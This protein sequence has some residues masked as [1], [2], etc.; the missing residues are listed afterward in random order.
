[1]NS[2]EVGSTRAL[3][4]DVPDDIERAVTI[5]RDGGLV[6]FPT[7]TVYGLGADASNDAAV[8][9]IFAAKGRPADHPL[10]VHLA[11][12]DALTDWASDIPDAAWRLAERF[13]P[14]PL[15]LILKRAPGVAEAASAGLPTL[16]LRVPGH[17]VARALLTR[18]GGGI[19]APSANRFGRISPTSADHVSAELD[20][21]ID[22]IVDGGRCEV[23]LESTILDLSGAHPQVL[24]PGH[25]GADALA[26]VIGPVRT[27]ARDAPVVPGSL[28]A[29]YAPATPMRLVPAETLEAEAARAAE[30][31]PVAVLARRAP[32]GPVA[33]RWIRLDADAEAYGRAL[34]ARLREADA[35]GVAH[36]LVEQVP[37]TPPWEAVRDRLRRA[38]AGSQP[39]PDTR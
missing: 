5:L 18:F 27:I 9:R 32:S 30:T 10:I 13:W 20:G 36:L 6:A 31:G 19:A 39:R 15:T 14:G 11:S 24:R 4:G 12:A 22:A 1:M 26:A 17:P 2:G 21:R 34:Y 35:L 38:V 3:R 7:E 8:A 28:E 29:H 37:E 23:G 16:G 33:C 25:I